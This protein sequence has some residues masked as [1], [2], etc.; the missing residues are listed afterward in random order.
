MGAI[1]WF[2][3]F[4][5]INALILSHVSGLASFSSIPSNIINYKFKRLP[6]K[7]HRSLRELPFSPP[8]PMVAP[9]RGPG[10]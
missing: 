5:F 7:I 3:K 1:S 8:T 10:H 6:I 2:L 9:K 4:V